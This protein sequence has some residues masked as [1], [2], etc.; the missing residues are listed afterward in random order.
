MTK[1][2]A[3]RVTMPML[4]A[5]ECSPAQAAYAHFHGFINC[6]FED[7]MERGDGAQQ[8]MPDVIAKIMPLLDGLRNGTVL[9]VFADKLPPRMTLLPGGKE[10]S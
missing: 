2:F 1:E 7:A 10:A 6:A 4:A 3:H 9:A 8:I 5:R